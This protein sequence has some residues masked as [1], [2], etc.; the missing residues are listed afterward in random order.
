VVGLF[1]RG[2]GGLGAP[3]L[4]G[5]VGGHWGHLLR[6]CIGS[7]TKAPATHFDVS[8]GDSAGS[9]A[10][11]STDAGSGAGSIQVQRC[12]TQVPTQVRMS[13]QVKAA[14]IAC[15]HEQKSADKQQES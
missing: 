10:G 12:K 8:A 6:S 13:V 3:A 9:D 11:A 7:D 2:G 1:N 5:W 15:L 14:D 4:G